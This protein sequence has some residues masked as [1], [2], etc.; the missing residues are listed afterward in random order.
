MG[1]ENIG[2]V[3]RYQD[4]P[5]SCWE[6]PGEPQP[7]GSWQGRLWRDGDAALPSMLVSE[8]FHQQDL[9]AE[10][11]PKETSTRARYSAGTREWLDSY[12]QHAIIH[13]YT[14]NTGTK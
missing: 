2:L 11:G 10:R 4:K 3:P 9:K 14:G 8:Q 1:T 5:S 13:N 7:V 6:Q 12:L